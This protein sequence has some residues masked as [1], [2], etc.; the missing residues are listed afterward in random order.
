M[1]ATKE[2]GWRMDR[3]QSGRGDFGAVRAA[4]I[5]LRHLGAAPHPD[6]AKHMDWARRWVELV[7]APHQARKKP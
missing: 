7:E 5:A 2:L 3:E 6:R 1:R 4:R